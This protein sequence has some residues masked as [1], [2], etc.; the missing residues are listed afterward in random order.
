VNFAK[1]YKI[2]SYNKIIFIEK[3]IDDK[4]IFATLKKHLYFKKC[5][6]LIFLLIQRM[7]QNCFRISK[8]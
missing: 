1:A 4:N 3:N 8:V 2:Y 7:F 6:M 5:G